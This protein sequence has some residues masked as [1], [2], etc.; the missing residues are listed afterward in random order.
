[1]SIDPTTLTNPWN[2][3]FLPV[4]DR[5]AYASDLGDSAYEAVSGAAITGNSAWARLRVGGASSAATS[6]MFAFVG[7]A[8]PSGDAGSVFVRTGVVYDVVLP[9][10]DRLWVKRG[11][12]TDVPGSCEVWILEK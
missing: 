11:G 2:L 6:A 5:V 10:G 1:M 7:G 9:P 3:E 12:N 8:A 4:A